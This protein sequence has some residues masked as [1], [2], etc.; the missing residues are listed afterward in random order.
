MITGRNYRG[1]NIRRHPHGWG[2]IVIRENGVVVSVCETKS[3]ALSWI[4]QQVHEDYGRQR[5]RNEGRERT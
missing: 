1:F 4:D 5:A 3:Q 2:G